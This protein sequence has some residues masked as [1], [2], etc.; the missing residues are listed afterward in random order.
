MADG[1]VVTC[2]NMFAESAGHLEQS[3]N[4]MDIWNGTRL[5]SVRQDFGTPAEWRQCRTC[6][7]REV[8]YDAQREAWAR[9]EACE[10]TDN[11][12]YRPLSWDFRRYRSDA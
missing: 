6:W 10:P 4:F 3:A 8:R 12:E 5:A 2:A 1:E 11:Q 9:K 7:F